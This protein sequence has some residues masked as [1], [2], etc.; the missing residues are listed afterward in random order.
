MYMKISGSLPCD[1]LVKGMARGDGATLGFISGVLF[2]EYFSNE[3]MYVCV[4]AC[5]ACIY[6]YTVFHVRACMHVCEVCINQGTMCINLMYYLMLCSPHVYI[7]MYDAHADARTWNGLH[8]CIFLR[9]FFLREWIRCKS[10]QHRR[11][12]TS[13]VK[14][15]QR[16]HH[17]HANWVCLQMAS[18]GWVNHGKESHIELKTGRKQT[19]VYLRK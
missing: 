5:C 13:H 7:R 2:C 1:V 12:K 18:L 4:W 6:T 16:E 19:K 3:R 10:N 11:E 17:K 14:G 8:L 9:R 15:M